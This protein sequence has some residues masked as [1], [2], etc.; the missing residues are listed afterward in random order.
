MVVL[1]NTNRDLLL[2]DTYSTMELISTRFSTPVA[3][4]EMIR[5]LVNLAATHGWEMH[6]LDIKTAFLHGE[7]KESVYVIQPEGFAKKKKN[8]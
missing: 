5:L 4:I 8:L 7:L 2:K 1:T 6:H 3:R